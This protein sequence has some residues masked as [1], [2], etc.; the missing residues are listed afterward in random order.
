MS[1]LTASFVA[2]DENG[3]EYRL[4]MLSENPTVVGPH[5]MELA[6]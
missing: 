1:F 6:Y 3:N 2:H 4:R 5:E